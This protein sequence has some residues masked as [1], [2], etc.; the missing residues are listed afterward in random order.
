MA[1]DSHRK[2][3]GDSGLSRRDFIQVSAGGLAGLASL[4]ALPAWAG[5]P[6]GSGEVKLG[7]Q[8]IGK[9]EGPEILTDPTKIPKKFNEAPMLA[10]LVKAGKLPPVEQRL[11]EEPMVIKPLHEIGRYGGTWRRAFTGPADLENGNRICSTDKP[12]FVDYTGTVTK[13]CVAKAWKMSSDGK[14]FT[15]Q[16]RKGMK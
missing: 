16:F 15:L 3:D 4:T 6:I 9:L 7:K 11:P 5:E 2:D 10:Q 13:P 12:L 8:L 1:R 14:V